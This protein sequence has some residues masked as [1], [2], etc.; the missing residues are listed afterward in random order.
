M[1]VGWPNFDSTFPVSALFDPRVL[2]RGVSASGNHPQILYHYTSEVRLRGI[3]SPPSWD[4]MSAA[5]ENWPPRGKLNFDPRHDPGL[6]RVQSQPDLS[7]PVPKRRENVLSATLTN[8]VDHRVIGIAFELD[9]RMIPG[10]D[11]MVGEE[12]S[13]D[14]PTI[15][16][17][18]PWTSDFVW[19]WGWFWAIGD[20]RG[21]CGHA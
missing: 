16:S 17:P 20:G 8:A 13:L 9:V 3:V 21:W 15:L 2:A 12:L 7:H 14:P 19:S 10:R 18:K 1:T 11:V 6:A 5:R 4:F